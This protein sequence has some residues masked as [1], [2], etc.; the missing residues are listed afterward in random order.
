MR[1][2]LCVFLLFVFIGLLVVISNKVV[3]RYLEGQGVKKDATRAAKMF[4]LAAQQ[5]VL[6]AMHHLGTHPLLLPYILEIKLYIAV[7]PLLVVPLL[8]THMQP[9]H[10]TKASVWC[11]T[12]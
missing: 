3:S 9:S 10:T 1:L 2:F 12:G 4:L 11:A 7:S 5:G 8:L 6:P